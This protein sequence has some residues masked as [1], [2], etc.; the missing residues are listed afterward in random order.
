MKRTSSRRFVRHAAAL[1]PLM[2]ALTASA[3]YY[4]TVSA[5][6]PLGYWRLNEPAQPVVP[7]Y[8]LTNSSAAG[9]ALN[10]LYYGVPTLQQPGAVAGDTAA[11]FSGSY[12]YAEVP[13]SAALNPATTLTVEFWAYLTNA[14]AGAKSGVVSRYIPVTGGPAGQRGYLFFVNNGNTK[15]QFRVYNGSAG[16]T[17]TDVNGPDVAANTWYHVT[18]VYDGTQAHIYVNGVESSPAT[19]GGYMANTNAPLRIGAG[20][21]ETAASLFFPGTIDE[22]AVYNSVLTP[23][24]I[25]AHYSA[26]TS[27]ATGYAAQILADN[28]VAYWRLDEPSLP[29][30]VPYAATNSG[31]WASAQDGAYSTVGSTSGVAGPLRGQF[32]G[33]AADNKAA[34]LNGTSGQIAIPAP[35]GY[36]TD[37]AT[38]C[39]W[40]KRNGTVVNASPILGQRATG[41]PMTGLVVDFS[42]RLG[43][44]WNDDAAT[45]NWNPGADFFLPDG[46]W[47]F[48]ALSLT[49]T[50]ATIYIGSTN[51]LKFATRTGTHAVH[52]FSGG[53]LYLGRDPGSSTRFLSGTLDDIA[54]FGTALSSTDISNLFYSATPAIPLVTL[55]PAGT[56][57]E[58]SSF[59]LTAFGQGRAPLTYQ[60]RKN[61]NNFSGSTSA[62]LTLTN[63]TTANSGNYDVVVTSGSLSVTS[64]VTTI[65]VVA[66]PPIIVQQPQ[67]ATLYAG[68][69]VTFSTVIQGSLPWNYQWFKG[70]NAIVGATSAAY[71]IPAISAA[72]AASYSVKTWNPYGTTN[73]ATATLTVLPVDNYA[74]Q[75]VRSGAGAYWQM[76]EK[77]GTTAYDYAGGHNCTIVG[78]VTNNVA[79]VVPPPQSGYSSTN[80][81]FA[82]S[83]T[84]ANGVGEYLVTSSALGFTNNAIT[85]AAWVMPYSGRLAV[86][87]DVNFVGSVGS[88]FGLNSAGTDGKLRAHPLWGSDTGLNFQFDAWNFVVVIWTPGGETFYLD[89]GTGAG[90]QS[91][92]V[93]GTVDP[94]LWKSG[95]FYV[96][97][98]AVRSDRDWPGQI[99][100][101][102][103][104]DRAL[105]PAE[106]TNLYLTALSGPQAASIAQQ[107]K[108]LA[109]A[110]GS[111]VSFSVGAVGALPLN[112]QWQHAGTNLPGANASTLTIPS[113]YYTDAGTYRVTVGNAYGASVQSDTATLDVFPAPAFVDLTNALVLHLPFDTGVTDA[114]GRTNY[115]DTSGRTNTA[116]GYGSPYL[117]PGKIGAHGIRVTTVSASYQFDCVEVLNLDTGFPYADLAFGPADSFSVAYWVK[118]TGT[119]DDLPMIGNAINSTYQ[120]GW[121]FADDGGRLV[122][123]LNG[124]D[125]G[126][127]NNDPVPGC[128]LI[129][130]GTWHHIVA[131]FGRDDATAVTYIDGVPVDSH[132][133]AGLGN[134]DLATGVVLGQDPSLAYGVDG[135]FD[136]DDVGIWRRALTQYE[137]EAIYQVGQ[138]GRSFDTY[139]PVKLTVNATSSGLELI[140]Q[141]GILEAADDVNG[142][143]SPV[144]DAKAPYY[145]VTPNSARKFYRVKL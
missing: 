109:V 47:T 126:S 95:P 49:P 124:Q 97:R 107:P 135:S 139:G 94:S 143:W 90:L 106:V 45:Y 20:T 30:Y 44:V 25:A 16:V 138:A 136:I 86:D 54:F 89:N 102:S 133:I 24:Q 114:F 74:A 113:A 18:G 69:A 130:D 132:S 31:S 22:V 34:S 101:L 85:M 37:S 11:T 129:N 68:A 8:P 12:Q 14:S 131:T 88:G 79:S 83:G 5:L 71:T 26:A 111:S 61:G 76:N 112:Y 62:S 121:V 104:F 65:S 77:S 58:G 1:L 63:I 75:V 32:A 99:D 142:T 66:G 38:I 9:A 36:S 53:P 19:V 80:T 103:V 29:P 82:F 110:A 117:V 15:W 39:G 67:S 120:K 23:A 42:N 72:D 27:N 96:A 3:D 43:Y 118:Y 92:T 59:T 17:V 41:S 100:E 140:W 141:S 28:P 70:T 116:Y 55:T 81:C 46:V 119:P 2:A 57:Y 73:S 21:T 51:G 128:P 35:A 122:W 123:T 145:K 127:I 52:D 91:K 40:I 7:A 33:F 64:A 4:S 48:A 13:Y 60:W 6:N 56:L 115:P 105:T 50:N 78:A 98:Q 10:G 84:N 134:L 87:S 93:T 125:T 108:S 137:A 144:L